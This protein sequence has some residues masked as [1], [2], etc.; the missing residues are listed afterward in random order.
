M[1]DCAGSYN[2]VDGS[3]DGVGILYFGASREGEGLRLSTFDLE[4]GESMRPSLLVALGD[5]FGE[6]L[7]LL[8]RKSF[9]VVTYL[10]R[11]V[12]RG[13]GDRMR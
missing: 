13:R 12:G 1:S 3:N 11:L 6:E 9:I 4:E 2:G 7:W 10:R 5:L 8:E